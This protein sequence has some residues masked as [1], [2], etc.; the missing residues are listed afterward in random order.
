MFPRSAIPV[1]GPH[2]LRETAPPGFK[3]W[4]EEKLD[5]Y[6]KAEEA[7]TEWKSAI[8]QNEEL[9]KKHVYENDDMGLLDLRQ[10]RARLY[11]L[12]TRGESVAL[13][14]L[15]LEDA[16]HAGEVENY[17]GLIDGK[18]AELRQTLHH[19][20]APLAGHQEDLPQD[21]IDA[22]RDFKAGKVV[23]MEVALNQPPPGV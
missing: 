20:H 16:D 14:F 21:F 18:L 7:F 23:D 5:E 6:S 9:F 22:V 8:A 19:W 1:V 3:P 11:Y 10:H 17:V 13:A 4:E 2:P 12:L 15:T